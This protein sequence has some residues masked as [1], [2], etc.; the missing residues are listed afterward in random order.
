MAPALPISPTTHQPGVDA[1]PHRQAALVVPQQAGGQ[2]PH[3]L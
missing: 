3:R 1:D 2:R